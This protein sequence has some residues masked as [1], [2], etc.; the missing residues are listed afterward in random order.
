MF[1][2]CVEKCTEYGLPLQIH[3]GYLAGN[4]KSLEQGRPFKLNNLLLKYQ[5]TKFIL[6]HG[7]YPWYPEAGVLA[8]NF[9]NVYLDIVWLPQVSREA[10]VDALHQWLDSI[11][12]N[13]FFWGGDCSIIEGSAGALVEMRD[14]L[15]QVLAERVDGGQMSLEL[16]EDMAVKILRENAIRVFQMEKKLG[17]FF[18]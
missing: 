17:R 11:P 3:T 14:V 6:L 13:K 16:A 1:H 5:N 4:W 12:Y 18:Q 7:G 15:A 2:W 10:A 9:P 8:K